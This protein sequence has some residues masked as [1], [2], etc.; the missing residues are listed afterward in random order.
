[1][2]VIEPDEIIGRVSIRMDENADEDQVMAEAERIMA[3]IKIEMLSENITPDVLFKYRKE[4]GKRIA[5]LPGVIEVQTT[6]LTT[7]NPPTVRLSF[8]TDLE[9]GETTVVDE[10][11]IEGKPVPRPLWAEKRQ[12]DDET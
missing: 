7:G 6:A 12:A 10:E 3:E 8:R 5:D 1:M 11:V 2:S 4:I 9:T